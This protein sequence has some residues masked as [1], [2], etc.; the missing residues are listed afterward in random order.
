[1]AKTCGYYYRVEYLLPSRDKFAPLFN[2]TDAG[3]S[4]S[5]F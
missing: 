4:T 1:M 2:Q 3:V 5:I